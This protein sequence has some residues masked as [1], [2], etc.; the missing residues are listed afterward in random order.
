[1]NF[2]VCSIGFPL[3]FIMCSF[4]ARSSH[5]SLCVSHGLPFGVPAVF[6]L[7]VCSSFAQANRKTQEQKKSTGVLVPFGFSIGLSFS[8][9]LLPLPIS[10]AFLFVGSPLVLSCSGD[11]FLMFLFDFLLFLL[12]VVLLNAMDYLIRS[13]A[14][15]SAFLWFTF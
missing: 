12:F 3:A 15:P 4:G 10:L 1:M 13:I 6:L 7:C 14:F 2:L 11:G 8:V 9:P 5:G